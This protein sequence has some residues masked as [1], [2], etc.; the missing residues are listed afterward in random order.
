MQITAPVPIYYLPENLWNLFTRPGRE[1]L[2]RVLQVEGKFLYLEMG[3]YKFQARLGGTLNPE[4]FKP[5]ELI[6][7]RVVRSESP[8]LLEIIDKPKG[9]GVPP[10]LYLLVRE[11]PGKR[12][13]SS[14]AYQELGILGELLKGFSKIGEK[15]KDRS[16]KFLEEILGKDI[17]FSEP[18]LEED[19]IFM[20]FL[21]GEERSWGYL[22][23]LIPEEKGEKVRLFILKLFLDYLGMVETIFYYSK[24]GLE[25]DLFFSDK[26]ALELAKSNL[27]ELK[28]NLSFSSK[29]VK[30]NLEKKEVV[31]GQLLERV[32]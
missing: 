28:R 31:P 16:P 18:F 9:E 13:A 10:I 5:G 3:G 19:R 17:K 2:M 11:A 30:I 15:E 14:K 22:E 7:V 29:S 8:L 12:E 24:A 6:R 32:G 26:R 27:L 25:V 20:P 23:I 21:L 4:D 1:L